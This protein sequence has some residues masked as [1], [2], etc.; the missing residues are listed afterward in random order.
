[1]P[2]KITA[3]RCAHACGR[4]RV[5]EKRIAKHELTCCRNP[6]RRAC[7]TCCHDRLMEDEGY[8]VGA[9]KYC[10]IDKNQSKMV[11][12]VDCQ[13]WEANDQKGE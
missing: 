1:M 10:G 2:I 8:G 13:W 11:M 3:Y 9:F 12:A 5:S 6:A 4:I 7:K